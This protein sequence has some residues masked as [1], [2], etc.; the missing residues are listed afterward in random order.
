MPRHVLDDLTR[1]LS[2]DGVTDIMLTFFYLLYLSKNLL[3]DLGLGVLL[4]HLRDNFRLVFR[5]FLLSSLGGKAGDGFFDLFELV[6][7]FII[8]L[9]IGV[10][11]LS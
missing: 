5:R 7:Q 2:G 6:G 3:I 8:Y 10:A 1:L 4:R 11:F 9:L